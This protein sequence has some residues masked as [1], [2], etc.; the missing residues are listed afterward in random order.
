MK[1]SDSTI[2]ASSV[3]NFAYSLTLPRAG[4][5]LDPERSTNQKP[6]ICPRAPL[7]RPNHS[8]RA[9]PTRG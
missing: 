8:Q 3:F 9:V 5:S 1:I 4:R 6:I 7:M 2:W